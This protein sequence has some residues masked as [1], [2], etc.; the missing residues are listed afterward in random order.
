MNIAIIIPTLTDG[1]AERAA[2]TIGNH[3]VDTGHT[4]YYFCFDTGDKHLFAVKGDIVETGIRWNQLGNI[5]SIKKTAGIIKKLKGYYKIDATVSFM[6]GC[7]F[8]NVLSRY[9]DIVI[10]SIRTALSPRKELSGVFYEKKWI[11]KLYR[12]A[13][14]IIPVSEYV[15]NDLK[16]NYGIESDRMLMIPNPAIR[17]EEKTNN[18]KWEYGEKAIICVARHDYVKQIDRIIRAFS[19]VYEK[20]NNVRLILVGDGI[21]RR[22]LERTA[23]KHKVKNAVSFTGYKENVGFYYQNGRVFVMAS[24]A[25]GFPNA[26]V[27]AMSYGVPV[28]TTDSPGGCGEI[29]GKRDTDTKEIEMCEYGILTPYI[30]GK[31]FFSSPIDANEKMLGEALLKIIKDDEVYLRYKNKSLERAEFYSFDSVMEKWDYVIENNQEDK[32]WE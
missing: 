4:V 20:D 1:G 23:E 22:Y 27:E 6:E 8:L 16:C 30:K 2:Q 7:N 31:P 28:V 24:M 29:V 19:Y 14:Y 11:Q 15:K 17:H 26:M 5:Q 25:E 12:H 3:F 9:R 32:R 13:D 18:L 21:Q 10:V